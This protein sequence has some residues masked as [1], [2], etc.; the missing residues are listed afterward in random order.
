MQALQSTLQQ[1]EMALK[2]ANLWQTE[3]VDVIALQS[4]MPFAYDT[5]RFEQ[6]LQFVFI[7]KL[8][9]LLAAGHNLPTG[10]CILPAAE[11]VLAN[12]QE[13][14]ALIAQVDELLQ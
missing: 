2:A 8:N 5:L 6:W 3:P 11:L 1:L 7:A 4:T 9:G 10:S 14:L 12:H 13:V